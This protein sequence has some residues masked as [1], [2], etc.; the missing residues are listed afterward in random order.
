LADV[1]PQVLRFVN[2]AHVPP[3]ICMLGLEIFAPKLLNVKPLAVAE[4]SVPD[5]LTHEGYDVNVVAPEQSSLAGG[6]W[7]TQI[8]NE[9]VLLVLCVYTLI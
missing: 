1:V 8:L 6:E 2:D 7:V 4:L 9:P 5:V 3:Y